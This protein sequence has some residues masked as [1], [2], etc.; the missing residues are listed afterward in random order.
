[1]KKLTL[2]YCPVGHGASPFDDV[3]AHK[4]DVSK[5]GFK[6]VD[7]VIFWGGQDIHPSLFGHETSRRSQASNGPS[8]RDLFEWGAMKYC[9]ANKIPMIGI[10]RGAQ[11]LCG[12]AGGWLIQH[13]TGHVHGQHSMI[14]SDGVVMQTTSAHHQ[15]MYPFDVNHQVLAE[16]TRRLSGTYLDGTDTEVDMKDKPEIEV[17]WFPDVRGLAIQG[18]PEWVAN[19]HDFALYCNDLVREYIL[20]CVDVP[21]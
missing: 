12:F 11:M 5:E 17:C 20:E 6:G 10:C 18:H 16:S 19:T 13:M 8:Q 15:L 9:K 7:A 4:Q 3:F 14:T 21:F 1:M 2:G